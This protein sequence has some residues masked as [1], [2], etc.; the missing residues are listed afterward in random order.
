MR[1]DIDQP[2][3]ARDH[4]SMTTARYSQPSS[5]RK[6]VM[7]LPTSGSG[8][9]R[10]ICS[11]QI[12]WLGRPCAVADRPELPGDLCPQSLTAQACRHS[13]Y[14][15]GVTLST[16]SSVQAWGTVTLVWPG[17]AAGQ[18][19]RSVG[20]TADAMLILVRRWHHVYQPLRAARTPRHI[21]LMLN[22]AWCFQ[23]TLFHSGGRQV[24]RGLLR[25]ASS[26]SRS[27]SWRLRWCN[28]GRHLQFTFRR[29]LLILLFRQL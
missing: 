19:C 6:Y 24:C 4:G 1:G 5:V 28:L 22:S 8:H 21:A 27:A 12:F 18:R 11:N 20:G 13:F 17:K 14:V 16:S 23:R 26:S 7:S 3:A 25:I 9:W 29:R 2:T 15:K 10:K